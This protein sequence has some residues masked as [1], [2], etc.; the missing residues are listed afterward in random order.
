MYTTHYPTTPNNLADNVRQLVPSGRDLLTLAGLAQ[1]TGVSVAIPVFT[2]AMIL[3]SGYPWHLAAGTWSVIQAGTWITLVRKWGRL[4]NALE[5]S[6]DVDIDGDG[7][8]GIE[9]DQQPYQPA[10]RVEVIEDE[11]R[12]GTFASLP[13]STDQL[14]TL[15]RGLL[16]QKKSLSDQTW[17]GSGRPFSRPAFQM[18]KSELLARG[19]AAWNSPGT[20]ARGMTL[21]RPGQA[22]MRYF[23]TLDQPPTLSNAKYTNEGTL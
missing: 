10:V 5:R 16:I 19:L 8:I 23:L 18:L 13:A 2:F 3:N 11:G 20:P 12:K 15:A 9:D 14:A 4:I 6:L 1:V 7:D 17:A 21:T 22:V